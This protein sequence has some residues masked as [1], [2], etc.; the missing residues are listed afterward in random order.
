MTQV[1]WGR[2][3]VLGESGK[4]DLKVANKFKS[5]DITEFS[6]IRVYWQVDDVYF[7]H[8]K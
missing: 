5:M 4:N 3:I 1:P 7:I 8:L 2:V 6:K